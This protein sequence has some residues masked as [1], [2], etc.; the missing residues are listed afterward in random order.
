V[1]AVDL[2][3]IA[4]R[5]GP[6]KLPNQ[7]GLIKYRYT[8]KA[9]KAMD[10][11][12]VSVGAHEAALRLFDVLG[13]YA[14]NEPS[15]RVVVANLDKPEVNFPGQTAPGASKT[16]AGTSVKVGVTGVVGPAVADRI[17]ALDRDVSFTPV[18]A[19][20]ERVLKQMRDKQVDLPVLLYQG[21]I[22]GN[23][24][25]PE[26]TEA[27]AWARAFPQF[28]VVL[29]LSEGDEPPAL[30]LTVTH[31]DPQVKSQTL[32]VTLG[33][34]A[35]YVGV[36]GVYRTG[37]PAP[38]FT[39]RYQ[40]VELGPEYATPEGQEADQPI[41]RLMEDYTRELRGNLK[42]FPGGEYLARYGQR[43]HELQARPPVP[44]LRKPG[45]PTYVGSE[46]CKKCHESAYEV[47]QKSRHSHAYQ[48]LV[49]AK[50]P[51]LR[52]YDPECVVCHVTGFGYQGGFRDAV[53]TPRLLNVGCESCHGPASLHVAN[54]TN[55]EW[56]ARMNP[57]RAPEGEKPED[58]ARRKD[59]IDQF[60]QR[61]HDTDN[62]VTW[63][64]GGFAKKWP[65]I[66]HPTPQP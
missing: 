39:F 27:V 33:H 63:A 43:K 18:R 48:A 60:C 28:P 15:P 62:D 29:C 54:A 5:E 13:G 53:Q 42:M 66:A 44:G 30:P 20:L 52:Q 65:G 12:A 24:K 23:R 47:W 17:K 61:C 10:Y 3:D 41:I 37:K 49:D 55:P 22:N 7:Q 9:L 25:G 46:A 59:R 45:D 50:R 40:L 2:G 57:W 21:P 34:K 8:M 11:T 35:K 64:H 32:V 6:A 1:V 19:A 16:A 38:P 14:L 56:Q 31:P 4:Q 51:S 58:R 26:P 36:V